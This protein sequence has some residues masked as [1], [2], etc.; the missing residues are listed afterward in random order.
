[1][2]MI[3][4]LRERKRYLAYKVISD[5]QISNE[6][7]SEAVLSA[8]KDFLGVYGMAKAGVISV[9]NNVLRVTHT[10]VEKVKTAL[11]L[12]NKID[13]EMAKVQTIYVSGSLNKA[14]GISGG[15]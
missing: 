10:E 1:M 12:I 11:S 5:K 14:K 13:G 6:K 4:S 3:P 7:V 9:K 2:K 15:A 8:I